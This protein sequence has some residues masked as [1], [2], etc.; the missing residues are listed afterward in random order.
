MLTVKAIR[1]ALNS[2]LIKCYDPFDFCMQSTR[3]QDKDHSF[4][5]PFEIL[6]TEFWLDYCPKIGQVSIHTRDMNNDVNELDSIHMWVKD[7]VSVDD[8]N[9]DYGWRID[10]KEFFKL[11]Y[12]KLISEAKNAGITNCP[13]KDDTPFAQVIAAM[14][15]KNE[16]SPLS[17]I[18]DK[19]YEEDPQILDKL[20]EENAKVDESKIGECKIAD[21]PSI[22]NGLKDDVE[23]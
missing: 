13:T 7:P 17:Q 19:M 12:D 9:F 14:Q 6:K 21:K 15:D 2:A 23:W 20:Y 5:V 18:L 4:R 1:N 22:F 10:L 16:K 3:V 8:S 11:F